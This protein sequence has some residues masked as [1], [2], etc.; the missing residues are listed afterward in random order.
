[1]ETSLLVT[2]GSVKPCNESLEL[3]IQLI[4]DI[5]LQITLKYL[6]N[7]IYNVHVHTTEYS[8]VSTELCTFV[9]NVLCP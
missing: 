8:N 9:S 7:L 5:H 1:M 3:S 6:N 4:K 2:V